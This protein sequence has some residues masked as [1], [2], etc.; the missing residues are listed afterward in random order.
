MP[1]EKPVDLYADDGTMRSEGSEHG[2]DDEHADQVDQ[3]HGE[4]V[5]ESMRM[6]EGYY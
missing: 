2:T 6:R 4:V 3:K 5:M 1:S